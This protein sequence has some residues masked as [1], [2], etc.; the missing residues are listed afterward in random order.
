MDLWS[1]FDNNLQVSSEPTVHGR[2]RRLTERAVLSLI[3][4]W[5]L[6]D[7][8]SA[9]ARSLAA[10]HIFKRCYWIDALG[11][12]GRSTRAVDLPEAVEPVRVKGRKKVVLSVP[13]ALQPLTELASSLIQE[14]KPISLYGL[15]FEAG[16]S[17][18]RISSHTLQPVTG[19]ELKLPP[20]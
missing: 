18:R 3:R 14:G 12:D 1:E 8:A 7:Y 15:L 11:L 20:E 10:T 5:L 16:S 17:R 9:Y 4:T 2:T 19:K 13:P 6:Q